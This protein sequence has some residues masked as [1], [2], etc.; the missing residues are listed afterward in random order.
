[1]PAKNESPKSSR[2]KATKLSVE[3]ALNNNQNPN[4]VMLERPE[5]GRLE[6][7]N[8]EARWLVPVGAITVDPG[9]TN[10]HEA[11]SINAIR[12]S[13]RRFGQV[14]PIVI[15][16]D[17]V[18]V[19]GNGTWEAAVAEGWG[20]VWVT[21]S[22]LAGLDAVAYGIADNR[23]AEHSKRDDD[24]I[25]KYL[26]QM[27]AEGSPLDGMG[28]DDTDLAAIL[29]ATQEEVTPEQSNDSNNGG[30]GLRPEQTQER[31]LSSGVK[32]L[33]FYVLEDRY[34]EIVDKLDWLMV[35]GRDLGC[36]LESHSD[37][38]LFCLDKTIEQLRA[39]QDNGQAEH[40]TKEPE[41][42]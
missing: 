28:Y 36:E 24:A 19:A 9:N 18:I 38:F 42:G 34:A 12:G 31:F 4:I 25:E 6:L 15:R 2:N 41:S 10:I 21:N 26:R 7:I 29:A 13:L 22:G 8:G 33:A 32:Q 39:G 3:D 17:Y 14:K 11:P 23:T 37:V 27:A 16:P 40:H 30:R 20:E 35:A 5:I 1:M